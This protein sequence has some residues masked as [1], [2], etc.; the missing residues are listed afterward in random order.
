MKGASFFAVCMAVC[1]A[2]LLCVRS[3]SAFLTTPSRRR[4]TTAVSRVTTTLSMA[5]PGMSDDQRKQARDAEIRAKISKLKREGKMKNADGT[6]QS[7]EDWAMLEAEA[8]FNKASP[9]KMF[10]ARMA[11]RKRVSLLEAEAEGQ[12]DNGVE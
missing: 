6:K 2:L 9:V 1:M 11:E 4:V 12:R 7:A 10:E 5:A 3:S 8:Y